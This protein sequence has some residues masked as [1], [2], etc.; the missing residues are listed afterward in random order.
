ML[1]K[2]RKF[3]HRIVIGEAL[4]V[5]IAINALLVINLDHVIQ[6]ERS[7]EKVIEEKVIEEKKVHKQFMSNTY[8]EEKESSLRR[9]AKETLKFVDEDLLILVNSENK[10]PSNYEVST[11]TYKDS[12]KKVASVII[13]PLTKMLE[14]GEKEFSI[15]SLFRISKQCI[16]KETI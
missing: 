3:L 9:K 16:S 13:E 6:E 4:A 14:A 8:K 12:N 10:I 1:G 15:L 7:K 5:L 2:N 11:S